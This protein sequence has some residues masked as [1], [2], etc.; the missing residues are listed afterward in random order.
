MRLTNHLKTAAITMTTGVLPVGTFRRMK[1]A[2]GLADIG[3]AK[4]AST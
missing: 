3:I 2:L 4:I 1:G